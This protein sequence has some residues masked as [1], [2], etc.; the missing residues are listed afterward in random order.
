MSMFFFIQYSIVR[1]KEHLHYAVYLLTLFIYYFLAMPDLFIPMNEANS[2]FI[3]SMGIFKRPVQ[4]LS[5]VFYTFFV[6]YYLGLDST[7][8]KLKK[9]FRMLIG[10]YLFFSATCLAL[11]LLNIKYDYFYFII[12]LLLFPVQLTV[13]TALLKHKV[14]YARFVIWGTIVVII[15]SIIALGY[16]MY[17]PHVTLLERIQ[18]FLPAQA[19]IMIDMFL[20]TVAMQ[21]KIADTEKSLINASYQRQHAVLLERE[22]IIADLHDDVGGGLSSIRMMS[23]LMAQQSAAGNNSNTVSFAQKISVTAKDIAQRMHTIIWSL[24]IENDTLENFVEYVRQYGI[25]FFENSGVHFQCS[26]DADIPLK[27]QLKGVLRKN[28]FLIIKESFHNILKH[29]EAKKAVVHIFI[30]DHILHV[31]VKDDGIGITNPNQFGNGL[32]NIKKRMDEIGGHLTIT[33]NGGT[34]IKIDVA[35]E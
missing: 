19:C 20:F 32:K 30:G 6:I 27:L 1:K 24:N 2:S 34:T 8:P 18:I 12:S 11:N 13:V 14:P 9:F 5:S 17:G 35:V 26:T 25:S 7:S 29:A 23:D 28:L 33:S 16:T 15:G 31:Q 4:F 22:R 21:K 10:G 3:A